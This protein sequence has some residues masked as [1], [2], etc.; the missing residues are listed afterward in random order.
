MT[1]NPGNAF[2]NHRESFST[3]LTELIVE[4]INEAL[5]N[6]TGYATVE[7]VTTREI[8]D[9][10]DPMLSAYTY[11]CHLLH[12]APG[13]QRETT[14]DVADGI[15]TCWGATVMG[16]MHFTTAEDLENRL[17]EILRDVDPTMTDRNPDWADLYHRDDLDADGHAPCHPHYDHE[18]GPA[19]NPTPLSECPDYQYELACDRAQD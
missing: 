2:W 17:R 4:G 9:E 18:T 5:H 6:P 15:T 12:D 3:P 16:G 1:I 19:L 10:Q 13:G 7:V 14:P 8:R 11:S